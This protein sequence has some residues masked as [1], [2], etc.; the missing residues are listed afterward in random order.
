[1]ETK[2]V[3][4]HSFRYENGKIIVTGVIS[5]D[6]F[7][8]KTVVVRLSDNAITV[9]GQDFLVEDMNIASGLL[10]VSGK[11]SSLNYHNKM[12]K[13]SVVKRLFK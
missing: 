9:K 7:D 1:M 5:V 10:T 13:L 4:N 2:I 3:R 8:E 12:E 11:L 6:S